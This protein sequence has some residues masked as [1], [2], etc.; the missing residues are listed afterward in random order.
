MSANPRRRFLLSLIVPF[1]LGACADPSQSEKVAKAFIDAYYVRIDLHSAKELSQGLAKEK[2]DGQLALTQ[3]QAPDQ[4]A[5]IPKV[6]AHLVS[7]GEA[8]ANEASYIFEVKPQVQDVGARKV[9]VKLRQENGQW[10]I[11][12]FTEE[13]TQG[14][15]GP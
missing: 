5:N 9:F 7:S 14:Q 6:D 3:G 10:K 13:T 1:T 15:S 8:S 4:G 12:Q 2:I 11:S